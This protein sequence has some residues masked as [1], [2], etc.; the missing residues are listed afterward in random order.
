MRRIYYSTR[1]SDE[2]VVLHVLFVCTGNVCRSP[3]AERLAAAYARSLNIVGF[4]ASSAGTRAV[5]GHPIHPD[6]ASVL[7]SLGGD[8]SDFSA[9][10]LTAKIISGADLT[11][12]MTA[13]H[14]DAV[15]EAAPHKLNC[16]F[17]L[18][19][20]SRLVSTCNAQTV[21]DLA[22]LRPHLAIHER[23]DVFDPIGHDVEVFESVGVQIAELLPPII[24]LCRR[25][26]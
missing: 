15:L 10:Q 3:T 26:T 22:V 14:R 4:R 13:A 19:E 17:T 20:A 25:S 1:R 16:T 12:T 23:A 7:E 11:L 6:A 5:I 9:R 21:A 8:A 24:D 18:G 2:G